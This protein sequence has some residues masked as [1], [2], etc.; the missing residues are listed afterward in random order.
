MPDWKVNEPNIDLRIHDEPL[1][2]QSSVGRV[3]FQIDYW[4]RDD[5]TPSANVFT[6][7]Q[8]WEC[9]WQGYVATD[10][11]P[12]DPVMLYAAGGG[13]MEFD[14]L[15][16]STPSYYQN[17]RMQSLTDTN[18]NLTGYELF[19]P[20]GAVDYYNFLATDTNG[21]V[22][23]AYLSQ[24]V[25]AQGHATTFI[26]SPFNPA[27]GVVQLN[28]VVDPDGKTNT[29][30]YT[31]TGTFNYLISQVQ[32]P[33]GHTVH[34]AY[35]AS[36]NLT[37]VTDVAG[38]SS[39]FSYGS[40]SGSDNWIHV[41][42][43]YEW[44]VETVYN[45]TNYWLNQ[46]TT[47]YGVTSFT[48]TD[49][50]LANYDVAN[51]S[52][53]IT[54]PNGSHQMF[55][56]RGYTSFIGDIAN[57]TG[58]PSSTPDGSGLDDGWLMV[59][60][61]SFYWGRQQFANLSAGF[62]A[63]GATNWD[64][65]QLTTTDYVKARWQKWAHASDG[66]Q[67]DA[68]TMEQDPSP[69]GTAPGEMTWFTYPNPDY[70]APYYQGSS[71]MPSLT[72][73][74]LPDGSQWYE[75]Y[76]TDQ[77]GNRTNIISTWTQP[78][79]SVGTRTNSY[80]YAANGQDLLLII[81]ADGVTDA[82]YG[83]DVNHKIIAMTNAFGEVTRYTYSTNEQL[84]STTLPSG[85]AS[86]NIY[87]ADGFVAQQIA[88]GFSTNSF[89]Y[90][91]GL[92]Y[93]HTDVR[94]LT[95]TNTWDALQRLTKVSYS[96]GTSESYIFNKLDLA[97]KV[98]RMGFTIGYGYNQ[99]RQKIFETN[100]LGRVTGYAYCD[101]GG[102]D[103]ITDPLGNVTHFSH[104]NQGNTIQ[105]IYPDGY[106]I[107][108][109]YNLLRQRTQQADS[110]GAVFN[111]SFNNQGLMIAVSNAVGQ[112]AAYS[113]DID[114]RIAS[115]TDANSVTVSLAHDNLNR[116][117]SRTYPN[118]STESYGFT[119]NV[120]A[121]TSYTNQIGNVTLYSFDALDRKISEVYPNVT[122]NLFAYNGAGDLLSLT[123]GNNH[124]TRWNYDSF[125][126]VTNKVDALN[127]T[128]FIYAFDA[129]N[130][131]TNRWTPEK[132]NTFYIFDSAG[133]TT[134]I[135]YPQQTNSYSFD[136]LNRL[137]NVVD[138]V[139]TTT[140]S[141]TPAGFLA[142][143]GGLWSGDTVNLGYTNRLRTSLSIGA[144][145]SQSY[146]YDLE[147]RL[148]S[149][150]SP[151]GVFN[152]SYNYQPASS[153]VTE[154]GLPNGAYITNFYDPMARL[155]ETDLKNYWGHTLDGYGYQ[156]D[157]AN[158]RTNITRN[159]GLTA[160]T[161]NA[162]YD[163]IG[164][165]TSWNA[166]ETNGTPRL[167][168]RLAWAYDAA[169]NL[170][171]RTNSVLVQNFT[172]DAA[173]E[174]TGVS[175]TG[176]LTLNG[177]T[178]APAT[179]VT[180]NGLAAQVYGDF[181]FARTNLSL[182]NGNN[183]FTNVAQ[184]VYGAVTT[185]IFTANLPQNVSLN[186][187]A[188]G[189]LTNDGAKN[190]SYNTDNQL[191]NV[192]V[193]S[194]FKKDFVYDGLS[195]LRV[196]TEYTWNGSGWTKA[197]ETRFI[198]DADVI[199]QLRDSNNV[200]I[201]TLTRGTDLN[202]TLQGAG[203]IGGLLAMTTSNGT[204]F[205]Y[206]SDGSGNVTALMDASQNVVQRRMYDAF[207]R[208]IRLTGGSIN[209]FWFSSQLHDEDTDY[210]FY[211]YRIYAPSLQRWLNQDPIGERGGINLYEFVQNSPENRV[212]P[213][214]DDI[215]GGGTG[216]QNDPPNGVSWPTCGS[217]NGQP[218]LCP[219]KK[220]TPPQRPPSPPKPSCPPISPKKDD[221][222]KDPPSELKGSPAGWHGG[223]I[224]A[225]TSCDT[226]CANKASDPNVSNA[227]LQA[228]LDNCEA[229][230]GACEQGKPSPTPPNTNPYGPY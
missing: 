43:G 138:A 53:I 63:T 174:L 167:N 123:D 193:A 26:Y 163:N 178:P 91:N 75:Q 50:S 67:S 121:P 12:A 45:P 194:K 173:N 62:Q 210:Y 124:T 27:T 90:T 56:H 207:G 98:D 113:L 16:G 186:F 150:S 200:P 192:T 2:Y 116:L 205:F 129:D 14:D 58:I 60:R 110:S 37:N 187:D 137:T 146:A 29:L 140:R 227:D 189:N 76:Q 208:T 7:G 111:Y 72:I 156:F 95:V 8:G 99:I 190:L 136:A 55:V 223:C 165:L 9:S 224:L 226:C 171:L 68:L 195:R 134:Q 5:R 3:S 51:R 25:D 77:W 82:A 65:T 11:N 10:G 218:V 228:C 212:D 184:N 20:S 142:S 125:G 206:H 144:S 182:L 96:D 30:S 94:G 69:D 160:S 79:G 128:V 177:A 132:G 148:T 100:A 185:N 170:R 32:D 102:L 36:G 42:D 130:R 151:A 181:T 73:K 157:L 24:K 92:V 204:S 161:V 28:Y 6:L 122:T 203:G 87:G 105:T 198:W 158:Q 164:E 44:Y 1:A 230:W 33:F 209:P 106:S 112:V 54:E 135:R 202:K 22:S 145:W 168:E 15:T 214:G 169:G 80:V 66:G 217:I 141:Y 183:S 143:E 13:E 49:D 225:K 215:G 131:L 175:R 199:I 88:I 180:V 57:P 97:K 103:S 74:V 81:G 211:K 196:K 52:V 119:L 35:D 84:T 117:S 197:N 162:G 149:L 85:L 127:R 78:D 115:Q 213:F 48:F 107:T 86:T 219:P 31:N 109:Q 153:L 46:L 201:L 38:L 41:W 19:H 222:W 220:P 93:T 159:L 21:V 61:N 154:I 126:R 23:Q 70:G 83:Y 101:C 18:G 89:T 147:W 229:K 40:F 120:S 71:S 34:F 47:P 221:C 155:Q 172:V 39:S 17:Q 176:A 216:S 152:Y 166:S 133:N 118:G 4:Q 179:N 108:N 139:G 188:N 59:Y 114:D 104:D 191:I 64:L